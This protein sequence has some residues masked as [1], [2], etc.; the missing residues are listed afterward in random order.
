MKEEILNLKIRLNELQ[1]AK[2][3]Q[4]E[5]NKQLIAELLSERCEA[6]ET[7]FNHGAEKEKMEKKC[8][9]LEKKLQA[10]QVR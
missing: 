6:L 4:E 7:L 10:F 9:L 1:I 3:R 2:H 5:A 8:N